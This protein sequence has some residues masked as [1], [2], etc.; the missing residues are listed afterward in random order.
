MRRMKIA[1]AL[2]LAVAGAALG[3][4]P[5][6]AGASGSEGGQV[7]QTAAGAVKGVVASDH[8]AFNEDF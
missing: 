6:A 7:V 2:T 1:V 3:V 4:G 8:R 5:S